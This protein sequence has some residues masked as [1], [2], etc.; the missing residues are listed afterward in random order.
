[1]VELHA[2]PILQME[3]PWMWLLLWLR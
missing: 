1:M 3:N 2:V